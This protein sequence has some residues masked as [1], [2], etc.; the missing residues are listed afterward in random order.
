M[1]PFLEVP[2]GSDSGEV[3]MAMTKRMKGKTGLESQLL[4]LIFRRTKRSVPSI[5]KDRLTISCNS[6]AE[7]SNTL[8]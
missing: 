7:G 1:M 3:L 5:H 6:S 8:F 2:D 4:L